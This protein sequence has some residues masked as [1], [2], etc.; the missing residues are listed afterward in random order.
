MTRGPS[1]SPRLGVAELE[2]TAQAA[3]TQTTVHR[4]FTT[5]LPVYADRDLLAC[6]CSAQINLLLCH[7]LTTP[8][9]TTTLRLTQRHSTCSRHSRSTCSSAGIYITRIRLSS[10]V[11]P[12]AAP[13]LL[14]SRGG[15]HT[16]GGVQWL[17]ESESCLCPGCP[18]AV[19]LLHNPARS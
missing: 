9:T 15:R 18:G 3:K 16:V 2:G 17:E 13:R 1:I 19:L 4:S 11:I 12:H 5:I 10:V 6:R 7:L 14:A 8:L